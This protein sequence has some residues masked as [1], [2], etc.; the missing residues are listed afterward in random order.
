M[1]LGHLSLVSSSRNLL[2]VCVCRC[3][4]TAKAEETAIVVRFPHK[5]DLYPRFAIS[6]CRIVERTMQY[7]LAIVCVDRGQLVCRI[8]ICGFA[9]VLAQVETQARFVNTSRRG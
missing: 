6:R 9:V 8:M 2:R 5:I 1:G 4:R 7:F 3:R